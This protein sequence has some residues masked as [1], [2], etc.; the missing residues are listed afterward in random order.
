[1]NITA[2]EKD[3]ESTEKRILNAIGEMIAEE[4]F[5]KIGVN[6][7]AARS[8]VSKILIYRYFSSVDGLI[9]SYIRQNDF[10]INF[11]FEVTSK[12]EIPDF[13]KKMFHQHIE[14][15]RN[16]P[17]LKRLYRWELSSNNEMIVKLR[18]QRES[19]GVKLI[20][21]VCELTGKEQSEMAVFAS[22]ATASIT[23][24]IMLGEFCPVYNGIPLDK[25]SG[26]EQIENGIDSMVDNLFT[27]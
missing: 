23:Y 6:A 19:V 10:W 2:R 17:T 24:L 18:E 15:L 8:G 7:I 5:E 20:E 4:G 16:N 1:M 9:A 26:W 11:P 22:M 21:R 12:Q 25:E 14:Q 13:I 27:N 3:R